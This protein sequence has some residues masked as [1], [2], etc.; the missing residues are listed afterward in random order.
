V[1]RLPA[2]RSVL[3]PADL[4]GLLPSE[5]ATLSLPSGPTP[6]QPVTTAAPVV[7]P[8]SAMASPLATS[9]SGD[10]H[11]LLESLLRQTGG[12]VS[13]AAR[14]LG[15]PRSTLRYRI[16]RASLGHLLPRD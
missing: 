7:D 1:I 6:G 14:R 11:A 4:D 5:S 9:R 16:E 13:R 8:G 12:N 3:L 15:V 10:E 2:N